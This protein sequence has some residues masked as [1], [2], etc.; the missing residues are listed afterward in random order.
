M[1]GQLNDAQLKNDGFE[2]WRKH[3]CTKHMANS[4][5]LIEHHA[6]RSNGWSKRLPQSANA[7][8]R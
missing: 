7:R 2:E 3:N 5:V 4:F 8:Q 1:L 6:L